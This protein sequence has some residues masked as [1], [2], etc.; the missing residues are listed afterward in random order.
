MVLLTP[1]ILPNSTSP[2]GGVLRVMF[3]DTDASGLENAHFEIALKPTDED[4]ASWEM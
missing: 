1:E 2:Y 3:P 4:I